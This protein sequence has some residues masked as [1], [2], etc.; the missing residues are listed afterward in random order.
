MFD[1]SDLNNAFGLKVP[2]GDLLGYDYKNQRI[3][4]YSSDINAL[5]EFEIFFLQQTE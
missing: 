4:I 5:L 3:F 1:F 2:E